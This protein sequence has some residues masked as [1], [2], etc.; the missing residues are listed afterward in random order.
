MFQNRKNQNNCDYDSKTISPLQETKNYHTSG[1]KVSSK[2]DFVI[3][4][5]LE[6]VDHVPETISPSPVQSSTSNKA[7]KSYCRNTQNGKKVTTMNPFIIV[8]L[9]ALI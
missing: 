8:K 2:L 7:K 5:E 1:H 6:N 3:V 4:P 9:K